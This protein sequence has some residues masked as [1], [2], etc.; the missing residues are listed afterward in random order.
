M[1]NKTSESIT[2]MVDN[3]CGHS[4]EAALLRVHNYIVVTIGKSNGKFLVLLDL[5]LPFDTIDHSNL[6]TVLGE[7]VGICNDAWNLIVSYLSD[8]KQ[9]VQI[10]NIIFEPA[11][12]RCGDP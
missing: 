12:I 2:C 1:L 7:P 3:G 9:Q 5:S 4:T 10:Y 11:S 6:F 8:W